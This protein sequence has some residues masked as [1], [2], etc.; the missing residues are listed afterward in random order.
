MQIKKN[1]AVQSVKNNHMRAKI[2]PFLHQLRTPYA[3]NTDV[4]ATELQLL[5]KMS[6]YEQFFVTLDLTTLEIQNSLGTEQWLGYALHQMTDMLSP[7]L[8]E[9]QQQLIE[10]YFL[11]FVKMLTVT[12]QRSSF[13]RQR[14]LCQ[15]PVRQAAGK[16]LLV[17]VLVTPFQYDADGR[18]ASLLLLGNCLGAYRQQPLNPRFSDGAQSFSPYWHQWLLR[19]AWELLSSRQPFTPQQLRIIKLLA[20]NE[21]SKTRDIATELFIA[22]GTALTHNKQIVQKASQW[23]GQHFGSARDAAIH[24]QQS[25]MIIY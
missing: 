2:W 1:N 15:L 17:K 16:P 22:Q 11:T 10:A 21:D 24:L 5:G 9:G 4:Q 20:S 19:E 25:G 3:V 8:A 23:M 18:L 7:Q 12:E 14:L 13:L 6:A